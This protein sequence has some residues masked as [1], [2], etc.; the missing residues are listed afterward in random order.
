MEVVVPHGFGLF[1]PGLCGF[2]CVWTIG[3]PLSQVVCR[4]EGFPR[5]ALSGCDGGGLEESLPTSLGV[6]WVYF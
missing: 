2:R 4:V 1:D 6:F 3:G 5:G